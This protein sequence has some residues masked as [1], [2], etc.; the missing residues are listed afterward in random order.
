MDVSTYLQ[1]INY[2]GLLEPTAETLR[3]LHVAHMRAVPF[4]NLDIP[5][6]RPLV[7]E[8]KALFDKI[9]NRRRGGFCYELNGLF[10]WL[11]QRLGF[12]VTLLSAS[13]LKENGQFG[14]PYDHLVLWVQTIDSLT[15]ARTNWLVDVGFG[16]SFQYPLR[17]DD[18]AE[19]VQPSGTYRLVPYDAENMLMQRQEDSHWQDKFIFARSRCQLSDFTTMCHYHQTSTASMFTQQRLCTRATPE[20]RIT[21]SNNR[22]LVT[23]GDSRQEQEIV[24]QAEYEATLLQYFQ[25]EL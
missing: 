4:E 20:G 17:L 15:A 8:K 5:L 14:A 10:S 13:V 1:R 23:I 18:S 2:D 22:L 3:S 12:E 6:G 25:I 9:V 11:L 7:L 21:L 19:Q 24:G 16:N